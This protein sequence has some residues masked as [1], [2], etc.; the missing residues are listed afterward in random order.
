MKKV[1]LSIIISCAALTSFAQTSADY[2]Y[3][4]AVRGF[5]MMQ[6]PKILNQTNTQDYTKM[7]GNGAILKFNDNQIS[8]RISGNYFRDKDVQFQNTCETCEIAR[9]KVTDY[10]FKIGFE[11]NFNYSR[12]QPYFAFDIGYR[13]NRF[14]GTLTPANSS[15]GT[16]TQSADASKNGLVMTPTLGL[17]I[18][19]IPNLSIF[20]ESSLDFNFS[21]EKQDLTQQ[22][23]VARN[24]YTYNKWEFLL[25][26][27]SAGIQFNFNSKN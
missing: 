12:I 20:A 6:L 21:Y 3:S 15:V 1:L 27:V 25:N 10:S 13:S 18:N 16:S 4:I 9:G 11:K 22:N 19:I 17:K 5:S 8:Y 26:P 2:N 23:Q 24:I 14:S 7:A